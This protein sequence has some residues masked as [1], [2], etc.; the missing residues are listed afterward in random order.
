MIFMF[1]AGTSQVVYYYMVKRNFKKVAQNEEL[2][3]YSGAVV[4]AGAIA[5]SILLASSD[6]PLEEAFR[7]GYFQTISI[8]TCTGFASADYLIWPVSGALL[9]FLVMFAGGST[10]STSG[11]IKMARHLIVIKNIR[12]VFVKLSHPK[13]IASIKLNGKILGENTNNSILSFVIL[14]L[15]IFVAGTLLM[16]LTGPDVITASSSVATCMAGIGPGL[17][18][19]GPMSNF[20]LLPGISKIIL[21]MLMILGRLEIITVFAIFTRTFWKL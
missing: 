2:W 7:E 21:S 20:A 14:Y 18:T 6:R 5:T 11:G 15:F 12:S 8:M 4:I 9:I 13:S 16:V 3:F 10:G 17:G 1:L 19:V